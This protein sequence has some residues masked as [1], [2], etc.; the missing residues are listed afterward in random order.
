M[1]GHNTQRQ[2]SVGRSARRR[3]RHTGTHGRCSCFKHFKQKNTA[4]QSWAALNFR[5]SKKKS[6]IWVMFLPRKNN[7]HLACWCFL[8][9]VLSRMQVC[10]ANSARAVRALEVPGRG[11]QCKESTW[12][13]WLRGGSTPQMLGFFLE[14]KTL[15]TKPESTE[16]WGNINLTSLLPKVQVST[17]KWYINGNSAAKLQNPCKHKYSWNG[18]TMA[19]MCCY[20]MLLYG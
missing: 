4:I 19:G 13:L 5:H 10:Y 15:Q 16:I 17:K 7:R 8:D 9:T 6:S 14:F 18:S 3:H 12:P 2:D 11:W 20:C 1:F